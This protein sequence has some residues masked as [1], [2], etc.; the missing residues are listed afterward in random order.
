MKLH[1]FFVSLRNLR[2]TVRKLKKKIKIKF[3]KSSLRLSVRPVKNLAFNA[4]FLT[5]L[6]RKVIFEIDWITTLGW[7]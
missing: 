7:T 5:K 1:V 2:Q 6:T 4:Y 3:K